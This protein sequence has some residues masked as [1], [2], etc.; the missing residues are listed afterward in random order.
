MPRTNPAPEQRFPLILEQTMT[1]WSFSRT[2]SCRSRE[3]RPDGLGTRSK[4]FAKLCLALALS[5]LLTGCFIAR[6]TTNEP[7]QREKILELRPGVTTARKVVNQLGGPNDVVQL[8]R[9]SAYRYD[10]RNR[11]RM[12]LILIIINFFNEDTRS[13]RLWVFFDENEVL[14]HYGATFKGNDA[15]YAMPWDDIHE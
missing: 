13:D 2:N 3:H 15:K 12:G 1:F 8:G 7:L 14:T 4:R 10:F 9:R 11:K 6:D 5:L